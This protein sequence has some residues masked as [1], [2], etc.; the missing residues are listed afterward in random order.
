M[1]YIGDDTQ[2]WYQSKDNLILSRSQLKIFN[3]LFMFKYMWNFVYRSTGMF[4]SD[5]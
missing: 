2:Y 5:K 1:N 3:Y 4:I